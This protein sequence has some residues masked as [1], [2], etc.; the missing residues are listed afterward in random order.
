MDER[1]EMTDGWHTVH[2]T[3]GIDRAVAAAEGLLPTEST[4]P[5]AE[6]LWASC[7]WKAF[8]QSVGH[9][10]SHLLTRN[11]RAAAFVAV[12]RRQPVLPRI[13]NCANDHVPNFAVATYGD[14]ESDLRDALSHLLE[15]AAVL[16]FE[17]VYRDGQFSRSILAA[18]ARSGASSAC[19]WRYPE[20]AAHLSGSWDEGRKQLSPSA[21]SVAARRTRQLERM[22]A[23][24]MA[25]VCEHARLDDILA[26]CFELEGQG[27]KG[28]SGSPIAADPATRR[29]YTLLAHAYADARRLALYTLRLDGRLIAFQY[30]LRTG[31]R[32]DLLK[33]SYAEDLSRFSP[34]NV[35]RLLG[36]QHELATREALNFYMG[37]T[38]D[39]KQVWG[40]TS[41]ERC[42]LTVYAR[43]VRGR[44][45]YASGPVLRRNV[46]AVLM[47]TGLWRPHGSTHAV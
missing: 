35:I 44:L 19:S 1:P 34:G 3:A 16:T 30:C 26:E 21:V 15:S 13:S 10:E 40:T 39:W 24:D 12:G 37:R 38:R 8:Q 17:P 41:Y 5:T 25:C 36:Y 4:P 32:L 9:P 46:K 45:A 22:G 20:I 7:Y 42:R 2:G 31:G 43:G 18:S 23:L 27:W 33:M 28:Q 6:P 47:R 11:G 29:F 14:A